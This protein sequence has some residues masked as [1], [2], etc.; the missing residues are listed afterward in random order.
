MKIARSTKTVPVIVELDEDGFYVAECPLF[1]G[2]YSQGKTIDE[3]L[4]N[5][6]EVIDL[7]L[8]EPENRRRLKAHRVLDTGLHQIAIG[9]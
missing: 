8:E 4:K 7:V 6:Q 1:S 9:T 3:A 2:C 5:I